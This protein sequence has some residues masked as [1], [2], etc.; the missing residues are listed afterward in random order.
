MCSD[1][2]RCDSFSDGSPLS[3][4][5]YAVFTSSKAGDR[6][7]LKTGNIRNA[8]EGAKFPAAEVNLTVNRADVF[9]EILGFGGAFTGKLK[10]SYIT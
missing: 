1:E 3:D 5:Q 4:R 2:L 10:K 6:F 9:Q 7:G 8:S